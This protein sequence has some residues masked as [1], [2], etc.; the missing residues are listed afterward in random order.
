MT[1]RAILVGHRHLMV[2]AA[3]MCSRKREAPTALDP[4]ARRQAGANQL[5]AG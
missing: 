5:K 3:P 2:L 4:R 1:E